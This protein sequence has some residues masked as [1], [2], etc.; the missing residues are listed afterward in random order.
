M[1]D[2]CGILMGFV[3]G[4]VG[5]VI[6]DL[7]MS[8]W[9]YQT[10][11]AKYRVETVEEA[12]RAVVRARKDQSEDVG[13]ARSKSR[14]SLGVVIDNLAGVTIDA[15][16]PSRGLAQ[17]A[18]TGPWPPFIDTHEGRSDD[19]WS[20]FNERVRP[21]MNDLSSFSFF[22]LGLLFRVFPEFRKLASLADFCKQLEIVVGATDAA[23]ECNLVTL[24]DGRIKIIP[25]RD[26]NALQDAY[27][28]LYDAWLNW[29]RLVPLSY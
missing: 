23:F 13:A 14:Y 17:K 15:H 4:I 20:F 26:A 7:M 10:S 6:V 24:E 9:S 21:V 22:R 18:Q 28:R 11:V 25:G 3:L 29:L 16:E 5:N 8:L 27:A 19:R 2:F 1:I 12:T